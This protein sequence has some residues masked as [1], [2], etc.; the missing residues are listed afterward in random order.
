M[1]IRIGKF[2]YAQMESHLGIEVRAGL[3]MAVLHYAKSA[4][5][6]RGPIEVPAFSRGSLEAGSGVEV[7]LEWDART[8]AVLEREAARQGV[9]MDALATHAVLVYL[10]ALDRG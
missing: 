8:E 9:S 3:R 10:A 7:D 5:L 1:R 6:G 2:A 4:E